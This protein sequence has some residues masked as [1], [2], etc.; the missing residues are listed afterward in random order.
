V[1]T[2]DLV[3]TLRKPASATEA[4]KPKKLQQAEASNLIEEAVSSIPA[5]LRTPSHIYATIV[6]DAIKRHL[7]VDHLHLSDV[8]I[9][10]RNA[11][12][13]IDPKSGLLS[14]HGDVLAAAE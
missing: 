4:A 11:G 6:R 1:V 10:L 3:V 2:V 14:H 5:N 8:L 13:R 7:M 12:Y 9:A